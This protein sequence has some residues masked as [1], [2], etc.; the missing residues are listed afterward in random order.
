MFADGLKE[1]AC[2]GYQKDEPPSTWAAVLEGLGIA[3]TTILPFVPMILHYDI[4]GVPLLFAV[5][6]ALFLITF[7]AVFFHACRY[8]VEHST[9]EWKKLCPANKLGQ[10]VWGLPVFRTIHPPFSKAFTPL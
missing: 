9:E 7:L 1:R 5:Y 3:A 4:K 6:L 8:C 10:K 2:W